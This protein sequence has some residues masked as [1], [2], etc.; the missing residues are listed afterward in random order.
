MKNFTFTLILAI[1]VIST[2]EAQPSLQWASTFNGPIANDEGKA[3]AL[4]ADGNV[5][6]AGS[7]D[8]VN[9]ASDFLTLK[10]NPDGSLLWSQRYNGAANGQDSVRA[11]RVDALGNVYITGKSQGNGTNINIV[12]IKYD[13][14]G[15]QKWASV[16][17]GTTGSNGGYNLEVDVFGNVYVIGFANPFDVLIKYNGS[18]VLQWSKNLNNSYSNQNETFFA[19]SPFDGHLIVADGGSLTS[20]YTVWKLHPST[21]NAVQYYNTGLNGGPV[22]YGIPNSMVLDGNGNIYVTSMSDPDLY[23]DKPNR[24][25]T[26]KFTQASDSYAWYHFTYVTGSVQTLSGVDMKIDNNANLYILAKWYTGSEYVFLTKMLTSAG[27]QVWV[28]PTNSSEGIKGTPV[29]LSLSQLSS[30]PDIYET[31]FTSNGNI[32]IVKYSNGGDT[33]WTKIYDCG[34]NGVDIASKMAIDACDNIYI[35]GSSNCN[36]TYKDVKT[37]KY[38]TLTSTITPNGPTTFCQGGSVTLTASQANKYNWSNGATTQSITVTTT[39]M[40]TVTITNATSCTAVSTATTVTVN[41]ILTASV[42]ISGPSTICSGQNATF[43]A[44]PTNGGSAPEYHWFI[45]SSP[46]GGTGSTYSTTALTDGAQVRCTM[47]SNATCAS[48][49]TVNSNT[50][51][52]T[53]NP[54]LNSSVSIVASPPPICSGQNV[55][56]TATPTNG[57]SAPEYHWFV[58]SS[59]V[60]GGGPTYSTTTLTN[61]AQ[62]YCTMTSNAACASP[63]TATS[64]TISVTVNPTLTPSIS[65]GGSSVFCL[66]QNA[67]FNAMP[68]NGGTAPTYQ[69]FANNI[70]VGTSPTYSTSSLAN[71]D[72]I[73]CILTSNAACV[74]TTTATSPTTTVTVLPL[75]NVQITPSGL[76]TFCSGNSVTLT[77]SPTG[78]YSWSTGETTKTITVSTS[79]NYT[80]NVTVANTCSATSNATTV[81]VNPLPQTPM[82]FPSGSINLCEGDFETLTASF[83]NSWLWNT[84]ETTQSITVSSPGNYSVVVTNSNDC[85]LTSNPTSVSVLPTALPAISLSVICSGNDATVTATPTNGGTAPTFQW[86]LIGAGMMQSTTTSEVSVLDALKTSIVKCQ[87]TSNAYC[88]SPQISEPKEIVLTCIVGASEPELPEGFSVFP[89]PSTGLFTLT[90]LNAPDVLHAEVFDVTGRLLQSLSLQPVGGQLTTTLDLQD[91]PQGTYL[92]RLSDGQNWGG[93]RLSKADGR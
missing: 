56:F 40:Y 62:V 83:E 70:L 2:T 71:G 8:D 27:S 51:S 66:G 64:N 7:S 17:N 58:N 82:I 57:G 78:N 32:K 76:T 60:V 28:K 87:M 46:V 47:T 22:I 10:Y 85:S 91:L 69:W 63:T 4:D 53:V 3:I 30:P 23:T 9:G 67:E 93:V 29:S 88:A 49:A 19:I 80:V 11:I 16:Y 59:P 72:Q 61:G 48:P 13:P 90:M 43:T 21:G 52:I 36:G 5:Y 65:I 26:A 41:P 45:N 79:G 1:V 77:A 20:Q 54:I 31:G 81:T 34:N 44:T 50:I 74:T 75:P 15:V 6:V 68:M 55:V 92:L 14:T 73:Y 38:S 39:G 89:N 18:G 35:T 25:H 37:I 84:G 33:L 12:T 86:W 42:S 24:I